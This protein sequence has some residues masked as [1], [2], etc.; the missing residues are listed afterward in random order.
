MAKFKTQEEA[1]AA[2]TALEAKL[3]EQ[4]TE[5]G[6]LRQQMQQA[7]QGLNQYAAW[8]KEAQPIV[9]WYG[10]NEGEVKRRWALAE[11]PAQPANGGGAVAAAGAIAQQQPGFQW[12]TPEEKGAFIQEIAG[13]LMQQHLAPWTKQ[14]AGQAETYAKQAQEAIAAQLRSHT[15]V[16]W[17]SLAYLHPKDKIDELKKWHDQA[18]KFADPSKLDPMQHAQEW[19]N[20]SGENQRLKDQMADYD[21]KQQDREKAAAPSVLGGAPPDAASTTAPRSNSKDDR[22]SRVMETVKTEHG[23]EAAHALFGPQTTLS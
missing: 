22:F 4:G 10:K 3:G 23:P 20:L 13:N 5:L 2:H 16:M 9:D 8:A 11:Q 6:T 21:K 1:E 12:L 18:L 19:L 14:F 7:M 15:D 17:R